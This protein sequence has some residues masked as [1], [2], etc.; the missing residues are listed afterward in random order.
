MTDWTDIETAYRTTSLSVFQLAKTYN[1]SPGEIRAHAK[2]HNWERADLSTEAL[3][4]A[5]EILAQESD[6]LE[7]SAQRMAAVIA[8]HRHDVGKMRDLVKRSYEGLGRI[9]SAEPMQPGDVHLVNGKTGDVIGALDRLAS[10]AQKLIS[11]ERQ[12]C[13]LDE[14]STPN[15]EA[16]RRTLENVKAELARRTP[17]EP[18]SQR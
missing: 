6:V 1:I 7:V 9:L 11:L 17:R 10:A 18:G 14:A 16:V 15:A 4:R 13:G 12:V 3:N 5:E 2:Q 8:T